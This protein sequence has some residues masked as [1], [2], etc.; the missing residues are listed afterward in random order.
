[1]M[2]RLRPI[3]APRGT[4]LRSFW[5]FQAI[6]WSF[7]FFW[8][9]LYNFAHGF[10]VSWMQVAP[11]LISISLSAVVVLFLGHIAVRLMPTR[12]RVERLILIVGT[13]LVLALFLT[14]TDRMIFAAFDDR[15]TIAEVIRFDVTKNYF[16]SA[17]MF[18]SWVVLFLLIAQFARMRERESAIYRLRASAREAR[19][20]M[21]VHQLNPHFLFNSLNSISALINEARPDDADVM[22]S[23]L[24]RFL[25]HVIDPHP[26][27]LIPLEDELAIVNDYIDIQKVRYGAQ[28]QVTSECAD[29]SVCHVLVPKLILQPLVENAIKYGREVPG[30]ITQIRVTAELSDDD[31]QLCIEDNGP[32]F[33]EAPN[34]DGLGLKL[35]GE[36]LEAHFGGAAELTTQNL[37]PVGSRVE[38]RMPVGEPS[39]S[40]EDAA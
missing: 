7:I 29:P 16:F 30:H 3:L 26:V 18:V 2:K 6:F 27:D 20:Q 17:W 36:R 40:T 12:L 23:R 1:M 5:T 10:H 39:E 38:I 15:V 24:S 21:L 4:S 19:M 37:D 9:I 28:L 22:I 13:A 25:R 11:R 31:L 32:G 34:P 33:P 35:V 14:F 8:R